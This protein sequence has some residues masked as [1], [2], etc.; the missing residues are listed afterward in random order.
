MEEPFSLSQG[1]KELLDTAAQRDETN[2]TLKLIK[3]AQQEKES[4]IQ[5]EMQS[6]N[7]RVV[8]VLHHQSGPH[9]V[10]LQTKRRKVTQFT[11]NRLSELLEQHKD[12][13][14]NDDL[15]IKITSSMNEPEFKEEEKICIKKIK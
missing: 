14:L 2:N 13:T 3:K 12:Q 7:L 4:R 15:V 6:Q 11:K 1:V 5:K 8:R 10:Q 9:D